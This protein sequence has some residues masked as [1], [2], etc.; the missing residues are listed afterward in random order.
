MS[1]KRQSQPSSAISISLIAKD[2]CESV[3]HSCGLCVVSDHFKRLDADH[4]FFSYRWFLLDFK[5]EF[6]KQDVFVVWESIWAMET[7]YSRYFTVFVALTLLQSHREDLMACSS[8]VELM[9]VF[10]TLG[11]DGR[12][13]APLLVIRS[14]TQLLHR[15]HRELVDKNILARHS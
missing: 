8:A 4:F 1:F 13:G 14:A 2:R 12:V 10:N 9:R 15:V 7:L 6:Q 5:R 11:A 3:L